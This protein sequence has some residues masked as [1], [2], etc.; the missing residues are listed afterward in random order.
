MQAYILPVHWDWSLCLLFVLHCSCV[1]FDSFTSSRTGTIWHSMTVFEQAVLCLWSSSFANSWMKHLSSV[2]F[3]ARRSCAKLQ[4]WW[5]SV[6]R[7]GPNPVPVQALALISKPQATLPSVPGRDDKT[8]L[9]LSHPAEEITCPRTHTVAQNGVC[10]HMDVRLLCLSKW[11]LGASEH[12]SIRW[13]AAAPCL[14]R[15]LSGSSMWQM[16]IISLIV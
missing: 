8:G 16:E 14:I 3:S 15:F 5:I 12:V 13:I 11:N 9:S 1:S 4:R 10:P 7:S 6:R 2:L